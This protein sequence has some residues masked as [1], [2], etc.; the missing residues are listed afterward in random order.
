MFVDH[1]IMRVGIS[2]GTLIFA[3]EVGE[4]IYHKT[5][6]ESHVMCLLILSRLST[7]KCFCFLTVQRKT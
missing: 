4:M 6:R 3:N 7:F 5:V 2:N 1:N